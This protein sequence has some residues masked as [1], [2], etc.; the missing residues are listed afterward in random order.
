[1]HEL[2]Y[3]QQVVDAVKDELVTRKLDM[4]VEKVVIV[5]GQ[6]NAIVPDSLTFHFDVL[7]SD[8]PQMTG[9]ML[10]IK[11][12]PIVAECNKCHRTFEVEDMMFL[13]SDCDWPVSLK[14][15]NEM[16]VESIILEEK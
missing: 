15:G 7:K 1:M 5:A 13:C 9:A 6:L 3:A 8:I 2:S 11:Q 4:K 12:T 10:E 16:W 14:S